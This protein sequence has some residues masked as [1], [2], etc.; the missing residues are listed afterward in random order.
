MKKQNV[1]ALALKPAMRVTES[2][3][4]STMLMLTAALIA[5][6]TPSAV[7]ASSPCHAPIATRLVTGLQ[8]ATGSTM[9]PDGALYVTEGAI[10]TISRVAPQTGEKTR[11]ASGLPPAI[12]GIRGPM[13]V[14][15]IDRPAYLLVTLG[16]DRLCLR[17]NLDGI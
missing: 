13:D 3:G 6:I 11:L 14:A 16:N 7:S 5:M 17:S 9:G 12:T 1:L 2:V 10:G 8:G 4:I 15:C